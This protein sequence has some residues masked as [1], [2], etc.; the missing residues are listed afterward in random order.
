[1]LNK[2]S[3]AWSLST[4][5]SPL[6]ISL[7]GGLMAGQMK[8]CVQAWDMSRVLGVLRRWDNSL[9]RFIDVSCFSD[10]TIKSF[11]PDSLFS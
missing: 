2:N 7:A 3:L 4:L 6:Y 11:L 1:M 9:T 8:Y 5:L 10:A